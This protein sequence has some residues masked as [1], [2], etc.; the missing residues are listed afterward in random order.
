MTDPEVGATLWFD[1]VV[2]FGE[3]EYRRVAELMDEDRINQQ[4]GLM[5]WHID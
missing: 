4:P 5:N 3:E 1:E 2:H